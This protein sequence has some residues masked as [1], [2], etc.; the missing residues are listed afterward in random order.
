MRER[1]CGGRL[2][3][4]RQRGENH[5]IRLGEPQSEW[6]AAVMLRGMVMVVKVIIIIMED[7][8]SVMGP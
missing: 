4:T 3:K 6:V 5:N 7:D 8:R 2:G 1:C